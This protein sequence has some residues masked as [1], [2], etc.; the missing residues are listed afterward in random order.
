MTVTNAVQ[1]DSPAERPAVKSARL[2]YLDWLRVLLIL[3]VF[4]YHAVHL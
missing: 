1:S 3:G 2:H 4:L